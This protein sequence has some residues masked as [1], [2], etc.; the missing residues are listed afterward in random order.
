MGPNNLS[1]DFYASRG[2]LFWQHRG[3]RGPAGHPAYAAADRHVYFMSF[4]SNVGLSAL[5]VPKTILWRYW[6]YWNCSFGRSTT[7]SFEARR[8]I[9]RTFHIRMNLCCLKVVPRLHFFCWWQ[10]S[11]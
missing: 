7:L 10:Y 8:H 3:V 1:P 4:Y 2:C 11:L 9:C 6:R 5:R